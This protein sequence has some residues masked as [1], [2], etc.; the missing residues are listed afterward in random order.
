M[1]V[2][3]RHERGSDGRYR[4]DVT[5]ES[6]FFS[7]AEMLEVAAK[8]VASMRVPLVLSHESGHQRVFIAAFDGTGNDKDADPEHITN[9]GRLVDH[10][11]ALRSHDIAVAYQAGPG[12]QRFAGARLLD[13]ARGY[14]VDQRVE[15]MYAS[16][17]VQA[18]SWIREDPHSNMHVIAVGFSRGA[19]AAAMFARMV[20]DRGVEQRRDGAREW[21]LG[22]VSQS[23]ALFDPVGTGHP[24]RHDR[25][26]PSS[27]VSALQIVA[28][29][30]RR[31]QFPASM[32]VPPGS[33]AD[34]RMLAVTVPGSHSDVGGSYHADGLAKASGNLMAAF[35]NAHSDTPLVPYQSLP[36]RKEDYV[37]HHSEEHAFFYTTGRFAREGSRHMVGAQKSAP[38]C[39]VIEPC[40]PPDPADPSMLERLRFQH[41]SADVPRIPEAVLADHDRLTLRE[42]TPLDIRVDRVTPPHDPRHPGHD[43]H[44]LYRDLH[45]KLEAVHAQE[46]IRLAPQQTERLALCSVVEARRAGMCEV[47]HVS[48]GQDR[49]GQVLPEVHLYQAHDGNLD[50]VRTRWSK[51]DAL[52]AFEIDP[53]AA[54]RELEQV[55]AQAQ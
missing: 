5:S 42:E 38:H 9:V 3:E 50:D 37:I 51:V 41:P 4:D 22:P 14:S 1:D 18:R 54:A 25:H 17:V 10:L 24:H 34:G 47:T 40:Q 49:H 31:T 44:A 32:I 19:E 11:T 52:Q 39:R 43:D 8:Q 36:E 53:V 30:E 7:D 27:V 21:E 33:S 12:T 28:R 13:G 46:G 15:A 35:I 26:L 23:V 48:L 55:Q 6:I 29:D 16:M 20:H 45:E 2:R